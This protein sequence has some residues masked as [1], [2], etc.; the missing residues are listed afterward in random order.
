M[1]HPKIEFANYVLEVLTSDEEWSADMFTDFFGIA[2]TLNLIDPAVDDGNYTIL[3]TG[4]LIEEGDE[5]F[6][7][8]GWTKTISEPGS[9]V[10]LAGAG[11]YRR[12]LEDEL[13]TVPASV[14]SALNEAVLDDVSSALRQL[15]M[16]EAATDPNRAIGQTIQDFSL[17]SSLDVGSKV[18][19]GL[20]GNEYLLIESSEYIRAEIKQYTE[21][22]P[23]R[24]CVNCLSELPEGQFLD[25]KCCERS[26][27]NPS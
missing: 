19:I 10:P 27:L 22:G 16:D 14:A 21:G 3:T 15:D 18:I 7:H 8:G 5:F 17:V 26:I 25:G 1:N 20:P 11:L 4:E 24:Y 9:E 2:S 23:G 12:L 13:V 6:G